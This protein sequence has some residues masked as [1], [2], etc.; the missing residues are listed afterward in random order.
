MKQLLASDVIYS[1]AQ[2]EV[3]N[4][5]SDQGINERAPA[6][7]FLPDPQTKWLDVTTIA[8][9]LSGIGVSGGGGGG[10]GNVSGVHGTGIS[11]S[12]L[13]GSTL[14]PSGTTAVTS[15]PPNTLDISVQNQGNSTE[16]N[17][18]VSVKVSG[19]GSN[20]TKQARI[21]SIAAGSIGTASVA[22][23]SV[24]SGAALTIQVKVAPVLG[25]HVTTNNNATYNVTFG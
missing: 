13:N 25:E 17:I 16:R 10:G 2:S 20:T 4:V 18:Q 14:T 5:F 8:G 7:Q 21:A 12:T 22:L 23:G 1:R 6:N 3:D 11:S 19:N 9:I 15:A 24:P